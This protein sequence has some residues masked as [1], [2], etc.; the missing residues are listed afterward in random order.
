EFAKL[1]VSYTIFSKRRLLVLVNEKLVSGWDDPRLPTLSGLRR[2]GV[3]ASAIRQLCA[4][5]GV[6]KYDSLTDVAVFEHTIREDLNAVAQRRLAVLKPIKDVLTNLAADETIEVDATNN[7]Q[8][9]NP[10]TRKVP[11][12]REVFI[13]SDDFAEVPPPKYFRLKPGGE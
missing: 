11:L 8:D 1:I 13:E 6:T 2:L 4:T 9:E 5:V 10:T 12:T 7:P 3:P